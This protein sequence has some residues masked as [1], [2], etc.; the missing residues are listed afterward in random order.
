MRTHK[1][2][3]LLLLAILFAGFNNPAA[4]EPLEE[5]P[6]GFQYQNVVTTHGQSQ[7]QLYTLARGWFTPANNCRLML[8]KKEDGMLTGSGSFPISYKKK[9]LYYTLLLECREGKVRYTFKNMVIRSYG[10]EKRVPLET[11]ADEVKKDGTLKREAAKIKEEL[12]EQLQEKAYL[13]EKQVQQQAMA[14][15]W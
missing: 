15:N 12:I 2:F 13:L 6:N 4:W 5:T 8:R 3:T 1:N 14:D 11:F 7:E 10:E 9:T